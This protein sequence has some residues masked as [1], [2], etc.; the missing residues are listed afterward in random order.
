MDGRGGTFIYL[1]VVFGLLV[2][3]RALQR[4][5]LPAQLTCFAFGILVAGFYKALISDVVLSYLLTL[6][7]ASLFRLAGLEVDM[8]ALRR[9]ASS[10]IAHLPMRGVVLLALAY[11]AGVFL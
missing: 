4:F 5:R 8:T 11:I 6:G 7:I 9:Q 2:V 10:L 3:P 1:A